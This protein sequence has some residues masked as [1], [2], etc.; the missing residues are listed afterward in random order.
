MGSNYNRTLNIGEDRE[1]RRVPISDEMRLKAIERASKQPEKAKSGLGSEADLKGCL[2]EV[3]TE[4]WLKEKN[5]PFEDKRYSTRY[6]YKL[7]NSGATFDVKT[8][9]RNVEPRKDYDC[10][11]PLYNH[12]HQDAIFFLFVSLQ[13]NKK[14]KKGGL[15]EFEFAYIVGSISNDELDQVGI[16][17]LRDEQDWTNGTVMWTSVLNVRMYQLISIADTCDLFQADAAYVNSF[18]ERKRNQFN[19]DIPETSI[20]L[21]LKTE[22][23]SKIGLGKL[24]DRPFPPWTEDK[25]KALEE[26]EKSIED[27]FLFNPLDFQLIKHRFC[28]PELEPEEFQVSLS[29]RGWFVHKFAINDILN[30]YKL[31]SKSEVTS[32]LEHY[33]IS[34]TTSVKDENIFDVMTNGLSQK[35]WIRVRNR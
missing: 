28:N 12:R 8:K 23:E 7:V 16:P 5:I 3:V 18:L 14:R 25:L 11:V 22:I 17:Y 30:R 24:I 31:R 33:E 6:D 35:E 26:I 4:L 9:D 34:C 29:K 20:N 19:G 27:G 21:R 1:I 13:K 32:L 2:G 15:K 10:T